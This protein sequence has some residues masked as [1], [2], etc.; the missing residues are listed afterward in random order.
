[1]RNSHSIIEIIVREF[2]IMQSR[3]D[4]AHVM[5][6]QIPEPTACFQNMATKDYY[7]YLCG[8]V[9]WPG[10]ET[11]GMLMVLAAD[12]STESDPAIRCIDEMEIPVNAGYREMIDIM[13]LMREK[14]G[15]G[16]CS[17]LMD[18][19]YGEPEKFRA[20]DTEFAN[21]DLF[22]THPY[23]FY[24]PNRFEIYLHSLRAAAAGNALI[25]ENC[26]KLNGYL[27]ALPPD[28]RYQKGEDLYPAVFALGGGYLS[29][30]QYQPWLYASSPRAYHIDDGYG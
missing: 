12:D 6:T 16:L 13:V 23:G 9:G 29:L 25:L 20:F 5:G 28:A 11:N 26:P 21:K 8:A 14:Y 7:S 2:K 17:G 22:I 1:M 3:E 10:P 4:W 19:W 18:T 15:Y 27:K 24:E 30:R